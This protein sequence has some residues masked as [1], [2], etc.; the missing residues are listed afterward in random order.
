MDQR[1]HT[2]VNDEVR[3]DG[4][5]G[6]PPWSEEETPLQWLFGTQARAELV[7]HAVQRADNSDISYLNKSELADR[8]DLSRAAVH[9]HI[10][11]L[12]AVGIYETR[13]GEGTF[14][15]YRPNA[16]S[17]VVTGLHEIGEKM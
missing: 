14:R 8:T 16:S 3:T 11:D 1:R 7:L 12:V 9:E 2:A 17:S 4:G 13:G 6:Y 5:H 15:R 10:D